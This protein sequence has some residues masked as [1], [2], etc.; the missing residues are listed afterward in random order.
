[1][2]RSAPI[3]DRLTWFSCLKRREMRKKVWNMEEY[4]NKTFSFSLSLFFWVEWIMSVCSRSIASSS[5]SSSPPGFCCVNEYF[6]WK[7]EWVELSRPKPKSFKK[8]RRSKR[9]VVKN[10]IYLTC[11]HFNIFHTGRYT[12]F[13]MQY[14]FSEKLNI[15]LKGGS[16]FWALQ[17]QH[18]YYMHGWMSL[19]HSSVYL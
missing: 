14:N 5:S 1:M 18:I 10:H 6:K 11:S 8:T 9:A 19:R 2:K 4:K 12:L 16:Y 17:F 3:F 13:G 15:C 7:W